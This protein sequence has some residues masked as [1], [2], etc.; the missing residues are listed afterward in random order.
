MELKINELRIGNYFLS[1]KEADKPYVITKASG[2]IIDYCEC[3]YIYFKPIPLT[4]EWL[5]KCNFN[6]R[7][8]GYQFSV[9]NHLLS[10]N[11]FFMISGYAKQI[12]YLHELQNLYF[13]LTN[14]E[15]EIKM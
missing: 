4:E 14:K 6:F 11:F 1:T 15:L 8:Y 10:G 5:L 13:A 3:K 9:S 2:S 7:K 12:Y